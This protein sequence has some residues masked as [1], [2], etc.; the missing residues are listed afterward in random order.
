MQIESWDDQV[1]KEA[2]KRKAEKTKHEI[3]QEATAYQEFLEN[4]SLQEKVRHHDE[5]HEQHKVIYGI[6][7]AIIV[8]V[9][10][11]GA[12][13]SRK[14][15]SHGDID[16]GTIPGLAAVDV[17]AN[18]TNKGFTLEKRLDTVQSEW[19]C[20]DESSAR[21]MLV[22]AFGNP[23]PT[24]LTLVRGTYSGYTSDNVD[25][26][27]AE[28]L[29][30]VASVPYDGSDPYRARDWVERNIGANAKT[31]IGGVSFELI[32]SAPRVRT[33]IITP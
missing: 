7:A 14:D 24:R 23:G 21:L 30:Y 17:H 18:F 26:E 33:L 11:I 10:V 13:S 15:A 5:N 9:I 32:A 29:G 16:L 22:E 8:I 12:I 20:K 1:R 19:R 25:K 28:F 31:T 4:E 3:K 2:E 6:G 27:A